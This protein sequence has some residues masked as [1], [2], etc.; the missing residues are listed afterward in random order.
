MYRRK[1]KASKAGCGTNSQTCPFARLPKYSLTRV[2]LLSESPRNWEGKFDE[3][4][5]CDEAPAGLSEVY[6]PAE[7]SEYDKNESQKQSQG[8]RRRREDPNT[9]QRIHARLLST[10]SL[11]EGSRLWVENR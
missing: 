11:H 6:T 8:W 3:Y 1:V 2:P 9:S 7:A 4:S 10:V 5:Y